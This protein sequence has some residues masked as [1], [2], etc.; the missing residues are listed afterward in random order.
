[1]REFVSLLDLGYEH[2]EGRCTNTDSL[3]RLDGECASGLK[4]YPLS[5]NV[6]ACIGTKTDRPPDSD[7]RLG[8]ELV[9]SPSD[10]D[11]WIWERR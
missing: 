8:Y 3:T 2:S 10:P 6:Q 1:M 7:Q 4:N 5:Q 9:L 11:T